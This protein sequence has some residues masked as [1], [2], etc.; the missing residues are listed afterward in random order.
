MAQFEPDKKTIA[1]VVVF[2]FV[3]LIYFIVGKGSEYVKFCANQGLV[4]TIIEVICWGVGAVLGG[5]PLIGAVV[6]WVLKIIG[7]AMLILI[8][9]QMI[10]AYKGTI[11]PLPI[12]GDVELIK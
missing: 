5:I 4:F 3:F 10:G 8:V 9:Y 11:K 6:G 12:I 1:T 2:P 7:I